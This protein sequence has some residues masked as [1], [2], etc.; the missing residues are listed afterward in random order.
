MLYIF[1]FYKLSFHVFSTYFFFSPDIECTHTQYFK[2]CL[3]PYFIQTN[4]DAIREI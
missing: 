3:N 4:K 1:C 2:F